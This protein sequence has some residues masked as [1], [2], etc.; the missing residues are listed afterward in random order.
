MARGLPSSGTIYL[1]QIKN[2]FHYNAS[3]VRRT[4]TYSTAGSQGSTTA[5]SDANFVTI[6]IVSGGGGGR[7]TNAIGS[8]YGGAGGTKLTL[9]MPVTGGSTTFG[10]SVGAGGTGGAPSNNG[11]P[12]GTSY[13]NGINGLVGFSF[14]A[15]GAGGGG[16]TSGGYQGSTLDITDIRD[17]SVNT[18]TLGT[19]SGGGAS[20]AGVAGGSGSTGAA[21]NAPGGGGAPNTAG[22]GGAGGAGQVKFTWYGKSEVNT[23]RSYLAGGSYVRQ[24]TAGASSAIPSS[25][26]LKIRDFVAADEIGWSGNTSSGYDISL[27]GGGT[28][29]ANCKI[30]ANGAISGATL[31]LTNSGFQRWMRRTLADDS[32]TITQHFDVLYNRTSVTASGGGDTTLH[33]SA[34]NTWIQCSTEPSWNAYAYRDTN[35][36]GYCIHYGNLAFRRRSDSVVVANVPFNIS[37]SME[38]FDPGDTK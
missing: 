4:D 6:E 13:A 27:Q 29:W 7:G 15:Y 38:V 23:L 35:G 33:G 12:G 36:T 16:T 34:Q 20:G 19:T 11:G 28:A 22:T 8:E 9:T 30:L 31:G 14:A 24:G 17:A 32:S 1:S 21:G 25:G 2:A 37:A 26:T 5:P 3:N 18:G 10:Y